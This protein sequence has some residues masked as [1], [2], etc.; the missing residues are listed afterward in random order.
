MILSRRVVNIGPTRTKQQEKQPDRKTRDSSEKIGLT[1]MH[2]MRG[3]CQS[4][5]FSMARRC[6]ALKAWPKIA[7]FSVAH[8]ECPLLFVEEENVTREPCSN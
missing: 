2:G 6:A 7:R 8:N 4:C 1:S 5:V 3:P